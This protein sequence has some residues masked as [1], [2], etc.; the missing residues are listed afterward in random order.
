MKADRETLLAAAMRSI[1][2]RT[3]DDK[4]SDILTV[5]FAFTMNLSAL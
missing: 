1:P 2:P 5:G 3:S 4:V